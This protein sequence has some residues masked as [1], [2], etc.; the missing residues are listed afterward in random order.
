M[1][2]VDL[3]IHA[4]W[5]IPVEPQET[6]LDNYCVVVDEGAIIDLLPS[7][8]AKEKY[9]PAHTEQLDDH[10]L[11]PGLI[12]AHTHAAMNLFRG[13]ADDLPLMQWLE[14]HIWPAEGKWVGDK[15]VR[16]GTE[17]AIAE[18]IR[19]GTTCF[20]DMY[21]FS[22]DVARAARKAHMRA[23][24]GLIMLDF[25]S[26]YAQNSDEYLTNALRL[27]DELRNDPLVNCCFAPHAPYTVSDA[28]LMKLRMLSDEL[29][30]PIT[31]HVH[32]TA[33][34]VEQAVTST[35]QRPLERLA[36]LDLLNPR[37]L[38]VHMT[39]LTD[40][41]I[42]QLADTGSNV[43]HCP[44]SNLKLAS[45]FC[46]VTK[47]IDAGV[48]VALGT[49]GAASNNDLDMFGEMRTAALLAKGV[50]GDAAA[51]PAHAVLRMATL[52]G[53]RALGL[54]KQIGS[55]EKGKQADLVA[56]DL[57]TLESQPLYNPISQ[58]VYAVSRQQVSHV[59]ISGKPVLHERKLKT[60]NESDLL[61]KA[62]AWNDKIVDNGASTG[63]MQ[64]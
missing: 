57:A 45:G 11:I 20:N 48:N 4:R 40:A 55:I 9:Q 18:M 1:Q 43:V 42:K 2:S 44:E 35:G 22:E 61:A 64:S 56:V 13:L 23:V 30:L 16:D 8:R 58:L 3:I 34:E 49:D 19:G 21:F 60:L 12:N 14:D 29:D 52:N 36:R 24:V 41:E 7:T 27:Q 32:E 17:L 63:E 10:A 33:S 31:M 39:Q 46:P 51:L 54:E 25:P 6:V 15:F 28:P 37:L 62:R 26:S 5:V 53:A 59:W 50:A 38:A 47:L